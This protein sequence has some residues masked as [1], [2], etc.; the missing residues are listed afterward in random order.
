[1]RSEGCLRVCLRDACAD[2][3]ECGT[4]L[5]GARLKVKGD[6]EGGGD[7]DHGDGGSGG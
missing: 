7:G 3:G 6:S 2:E 4:V 1:M 5:V